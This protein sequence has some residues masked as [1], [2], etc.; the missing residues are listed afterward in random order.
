MRACGGVFNQLE[1]HA[2]YEGSPLSGDRWYARVRR[3]TMAKNVGT[4]RGKYQKPDGGV[5]LETGRA[6]DPRLGAARHDYGR[7]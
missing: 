7:F 4:I 5:S 6:V 3:Y 2:H 1:L